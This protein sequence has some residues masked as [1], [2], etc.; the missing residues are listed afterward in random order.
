[1]RINVDEF[2]RL[3]PFEA[4]QQF[5]LDELLDIIL[6]GTPKSWQKE[7]DKQG[8]DPMDQTINEVVDFMERLEGIEDFDA[9]K[10]VKQ[11]AKKHGHGKGGKKSSNSNG[12]QTQYCIYH[13]EGNHK[14]EDCYQL[15]K[16]AKRLKKDGG[17]SSGNDGKFKNKTWTRKAAESS[18]ASKNDLKAFIRKEIQKGV[19]KD[20]KALGK[21]KRKSSDDSDSSDADGYLFDLK[22]FNYEDME[23]LKIDDD[24]TDE[25]ST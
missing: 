17:K 14:T 13:G 10:N 18:N 5:S 12:K 6:F 3:P 16:E 20:L 8:F 25:V 23:N 19:K 4:N 21:K 1:M 2:Q 22:D 15:I 7:M 24:V 11:A 9:D